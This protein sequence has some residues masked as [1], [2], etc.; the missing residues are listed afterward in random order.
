VSVDPAYVVGLL[1]RLRERGGDSTDI[2]VKLGLGGVPRL[3][4]TLC[5]FGNMPTGGTLIIGLDETNDFEP[6]GVADPAAMAASIAA[7][8]RQAVVPPVQVDFDEARVDGVVLLVA[9]VAP[10]PLSARPCRYQGNAYLRQADGDY[11]MSEQEVQQILAQRDRPRHDAAVVAETTK[12]DL[13]RELVESFI[14]SA[15]STNP[16]LRDVDE[17]EVLRRTR[18]LSPR[19]PEL[20]IGGLYALGAYPQQFAPSLSITAA[21]QLDPRSGARTRDLAHLAGPIPMLLEDA[22]AWVVRNTR[23]TIRYTADGHARDFEEIP[24]I[25]VRELVANALV[26]RGLSAHSQSKRVELRLTDD[27]LVISNPGGLWGINRAQLGTPMGKSAVN[28]FLYDICKLTRTANG[29]RVI[30]GEGGGIRDAQRV[31]SAANLRPPKFIDSGVS[32]TVLIPRISLLSVQDLEWLYE[33]DPNGRLSAVQ[34][35]LAAGLRHGR[36]WTNASVREDFAPM[37]SVVARAELQGLVATGIAVADGERGQTT[38]RLAD[39]LDVAAGSD[40]R[41]HVSV[42]HLTGD[43]RAQGVT[44]DHEDTALPSTVGP[45][46]DVTTH[47][48]AVWSALGSGNVGVMEL[49]ARTGLKVHQVSYALKRLRQTGWIDIHGGWGDRGTTYRRKAMP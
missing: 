21:V 46:N 11:A 39:A 18:V 23:T 26:H 44:V 6:I 31:I 33:K 49:A 5:A 32:F 8:A 27:N 7:Q 13:N 40:A 28:E 45:G 43:A 16:L 38:Y 37:D 25:A 3:G 34:R 2:E 19:G 24:A 29:S 30:E 47:G 10:L 22:M 35:R 4:D 36:T 48:P 20:T 9:S 17:D 12:A 41:G 14:A 1:A 42:R 15:R